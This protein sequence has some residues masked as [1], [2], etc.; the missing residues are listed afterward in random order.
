MKRIID[1]R[2]W[3]D[4]KFREE[5]PRLGQILWLY[6]L[7]NEKSTSI[8][9]YAINFDKIAFDTKLSIEEVKQYLMKLTDLE[10]LEYDTKTKEVLIYNSPIY[11]WN[12]AGKPIYD[13][14]RSELSNVKCFALIQKSYQHLM[15]YVEEHPQDKR[16]KTISYILP[17]Y[18]DLLSTFKKPLLGKGDKEDIVNLVDKPK[19]KN[20]YIN[21]NNESY[22]DTCHESLE[23][24]K[25]FTDLV[26]DLEQER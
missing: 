8:G 5:L 4:D 13:M 1:T 7:T 21:I 16:I 18:K 6:L 15:N 22:H 26:D 23:T 14:V 25:S 11:N 20:I 2:L 19:D 12:S 24:E 10:M 3:E 9:I 17:I